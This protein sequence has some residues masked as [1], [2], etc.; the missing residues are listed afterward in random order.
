MRVLTTYYHFILF[1]ERSHT[2]IYSKSLIS[3]LKRSMTGWPT[4]RSS[5]TWTPKARIISCPLGIHPPMVLD[6]LTE[7]S[8]ARCS[9]PSPCSFYLAKCWMV[10]QYAFGSMGPTI[11]SKSCPTTK[12][13]L[14]RWTSTVAISATKISRS[15]RWIKKLPLTLMLYHNEDKKLQAF[16]KLEYSSCI[17]NF[18]VS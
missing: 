18:L 16:C 9:T 3:V 13:Q 5:S 12:L 8:K 2:K 1:S 15:R 14:V 11:A 4:A 6:H 10:K 7:L 17:I